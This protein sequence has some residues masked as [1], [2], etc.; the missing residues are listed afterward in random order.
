[1]LFNSGVFLKFFAGFLLLYW[2]VRSN[3]R[4]RNIL[5]VLASYLFYGWWDYRFLGLI[6]FSSVLDYVVGLGIARQTNARRRKLWL[7]LSIVA[8]L[9][10]LGFFKYF[11]FFVTSMEVLLQRL[12]IPFHTTTLRI[13]LPVGI[14]FYT[15]QAMSYTIDVYRGAIPACRNLVNFLAFVSFFPQLVAGPIER[16]GHLLPQF[17]RT[18]AINR[19]MLEEGVWLIVWGMFKKVV[20]AD[21]LDPLVNMVYDNGTYAGPAVALATIA[22]GFQIY[23]DFSGYS[24]I[25]RG[26]ARVLGF[27]IMVNFNLPYFASN[28]REFW[29]RW[30]ISLSTWLRDYLYISLGGN[31]RGEMRTYANLLITMLLGG[32]WHGAAWHFV[33]WGAWHGIGLIVHRVAA[34]RLQIPRIIGWFATMLFVFYGWMLFRAQSFDQVVNM[35][36]ALSMW[37]SP[38]WIGSYVTN[39]AVL[40]VPLLAIEAW[41]FRSRNLLVPLTLSRWALALL[42]GLLLLAIVLYWERTDV[43]FIYFQ[44]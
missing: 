32:L 24:D 33:L 25:A 18:L 41:Q 23:C 11:D 9:G 29:Q 21:N 13:V 37:S 39:L 3:L 12:E 36:R 10:I 27:D 1:M 34:G 20:I 31:R 15:F 44:F 16:A 42:Q 40:I 5:I 7:T 8:N 22:F 4:A 38:I 35:T 6:L 26:L 2:L 28:I 19:A 14:S 30:H 43:P 17:E